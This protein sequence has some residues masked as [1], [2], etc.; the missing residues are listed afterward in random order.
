MKIMGKITGVLA[1]V[2]IAAS[3]L[4]M[5]AA[6]AVAQERPLPPIPG[7]EAGCE[8]AFVKELPDNVR[9]AGLRTTDAETGL[10]RS[11]V[12]YVVG[13][14]VRAVSEPVEVAHIEDAACG[15]DGDAQRCLVSYGVG[16]HS[17]N[18]V[19]LLLTWDR[20]IEVTDTVDAGTPTYVLTD[21]DHSGRPDAA[22]RQSTYDPAYASAP[23]YW[24]TW[25]E[26][27]GTFVRTGCGPLSTAAEPP[28]TSPL[29][30]SC[31]LA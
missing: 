15:Y 27:E 23:Q 22:V 26:F 5:A 17:T 12:A 3:A 31:E 29:Y 28:P 25:L 7:C 8:V 24:E 10:I 16:A 18:V 2:G 4:V 19:S 20:G 14:Q 30:G 6:P 9:L 11:L 21:L 1:A 13:E